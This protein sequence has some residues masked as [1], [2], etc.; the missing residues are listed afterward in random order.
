[1]ARQQHNELKLT[2]KQYC[3]FVNTKQLHSLKNIAIKV[4]EHQIK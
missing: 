4:K 2:P 3:Y 1:M